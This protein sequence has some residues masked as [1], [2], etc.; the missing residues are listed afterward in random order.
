MSVK[1]GQTIEIPSIYDPSKT[2]IILGDDFEASVGAVH[3]QAKLDHQR[4]HN[5]TVAQAELESSALANGRRGLS[6]KNPSDSLAA[7]KKRQ[8]EE[9][10][11]RSLLKQLQNR[12]EDIYRQIEVINQRL[13]E[14]DTEISELERLK[15]L[16]ESE[17]LDPTNPDHARLLKKY[18]ITQEDIDSG[19]LSAILAKKLG[20]RFD[21][22]TELQKRKE[23]LQ[24]Q[25][26]KA[27]EEV[28]TN[29]AITSEEA[30]QLR[31]Q[32]R[33]RLQSLE[34]GVS[35]Q[36]RI[37]VEASQQLKDIA[38]DH[39]TDEVDHSSISGELDFLAV[40]PSS[41]SVSASLDGDATYQ[42]GIQ[43]QGEP[44]SL[45]DKFTA[46]AK[47][48]ENNLGLEEVASNPIAPGLKKG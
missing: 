48:E 39:Y 38:V 43:S 32:F 31:Q 21:E 11:H 14:I 4:D 44:I 10:T 27:I 2:E 22:R 46:K 12:L 23:S 26:D 29:G 37:T 7:R 42:K 16:A 6:H 19:N 8:K 1:H 34:T 45:Q 9:A 47:H 33:Q 24:Y 35:S 13:D 30:G 5:H 40:S 25:A 15:E 3:E 20:H 28:Q 36:V 18:G 17:L 41:G